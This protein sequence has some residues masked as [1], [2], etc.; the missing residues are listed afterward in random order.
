LIVSLVKNGSEG[1]IAL[2]F[3]SVSNISISKY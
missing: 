3:L 2:P 1:L